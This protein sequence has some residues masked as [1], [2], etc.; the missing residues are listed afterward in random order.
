MGKSGGRPRSVFYKKFFICLFIISLAALV[1]ALIV[2][3]W[4]QD[5][6]EEV[7]NGKYE[8]LQIPVGPAVEITDAS[9]SAEPRDDQ[10]TF[11]KCF[12]VYECGYNDQT[13]ISIYVYPIQQV[14][15]FVSV[16]IFG[17]FTELLTLLYV[18]IL[19]K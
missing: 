9:P 4:P 5:T 15:G 19:S 2:L 7:T 8:P 16:E 1:L 12:N 11:H 10:C 17:I 14:R 6:L 18:L 3:V 13:R